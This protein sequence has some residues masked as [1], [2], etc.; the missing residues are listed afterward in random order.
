M[1]LGQEVR[2]FGG[3]VSSSLLLLV[4]A[5]LVLGLLLAILCAPLAPFALGVL[6]SFCIFPGLL[7]VPLRIHLNLRL[8]LRLLRLATFGLLCS[9]ALL[10]LRALLLLAASTWLLSSGLRQRNSHRRGWF[11]FARTLQTL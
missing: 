1:Q 2:D 5:F 9:L 6:C 11:G 7:P 8:L 4:L 10:L 3:V